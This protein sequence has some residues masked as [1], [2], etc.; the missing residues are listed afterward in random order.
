MLL[1]VLQ[2]S[3]AHP[4]FLLFAERAENPPPMFS[5]IAHSI[6][7]KYGWVA[8]SVC[9]RCLISGWCPDFVPSE[10]HYSDFQYP[11]IRDGCKV[12]PAIRCESELLEHV[13]ALADFRFDREKTSVHLYYLN[14]EGERLLSPP[15][16]E[17]T[18]AWNPFLLP[19]LL[20]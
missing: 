2:S 18:E 12:P 5:G 15:Q 19:W 17:D 6:W 8:A 4:A 20:L 10:R 3:S 14:V 7:R 13:S 9:Y 16:C 11:F 1:T